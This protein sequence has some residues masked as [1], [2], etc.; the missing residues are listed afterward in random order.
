LAPFWRCADRG[1]QDL[2][3]LGRMAGDRVPILFIAV[4]VPEVNVK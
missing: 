3:A 2:G 4:M 1:L